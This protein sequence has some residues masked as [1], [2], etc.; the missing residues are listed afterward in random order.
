MT[1]CLNQ[2]TVLLG[3]LSIACGI[4][5]NHPGR[6]INLNEKWESESNIT[7]PEDYTTWASVGHAPYSTGKYHLAYQR[8]P[9]ECRSFVSEDVEDAIQQMKHAITDPDLFRLFENSYPNTLDTTVKWQGTVEGS[10]E[11]LTFVITGD[12]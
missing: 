6:F 12:M 1:T 2:I 5:I 7:C 11:E 8:P 10:D 9:P 3:L 4:S